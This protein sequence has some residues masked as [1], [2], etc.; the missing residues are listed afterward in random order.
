MEITVYEAAWL[1]QRIANDHAEGR[2]QHVPLVAAGR[3]AQVALQEPFRHDFQPARQHGMV[4]RWQPAVI[5]PGLHAQQRIHRVAVERIRGV[6]VQC[7]QIQ[8]R[9]QVFDQQETLLQVVCIHGRHVQADCGQL[10]ANRQPRPRIFLC[11]RRVHHDPA[12]PL[13]LHAP[14][15]AKAGI[16][17]GRCQRQRGIAEDAAG[18]GEAGDGAVLNAVHEV[19]R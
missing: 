18:P 15:T 10:R 5:H 9:T 6:F 1:L 4:E 17:R 12:A 14:V 8:L 19:D 16:R 2:F 3:V 7:R 13:V 11:R